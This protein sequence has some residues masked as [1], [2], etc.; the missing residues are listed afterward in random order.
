MNQKTDKR[1]IFYAVLAGLA[2]IATALPWMRIK[3]AFVGGGSL[4]SGLTLPYT[5]KTLINGTSTLAQ[6]LN[7]NL[8][9][10]INALG[11]FNLSVMFAVSLLIYIEPVMYGIACYFLLAKK[12]VDQFTKM[13]LCGL[14]VTAAMSIY[15]LLACIGLN[16]QVQQALGSSLGT[17][18]L[19]GIAQVHFF[20]V[21]SGLILA[22]VISLFGLIY[23]LVIRQ[24]V[25][26]G[27]KVSP[28]SLEISGIQPQFS[29]QP[30]P[31][32]QPRPVQPEAG[33]PHPAAPQSR[34]TIA[35]R[36][37]SGRQNDLMLT[38]FPAV[39]GRDRRQ[40]SA[41]LDDPSVGA[42]H[43]VINVEQGQVVICDLGSVKGTRI[44]GEKIAADT[45][46]A[47]MDGD[48][49]TIGDV[50][51]TVDMDGDSVGEKSGDA[52]A[53]DE[54]GRTTILADAPKAEANSATIPINY[55]GG[56]SPFPVKVMAW[57]DGRD[58]FMI[59]KTPF[60]LG[61]EAEKVDYVIEDRGIS[62]Q[63]LAITR[64]NETFFAEDLNSKNG[65]K[66]N[67]IQKAPGA[68]AKIKNGD[69]LTIGV[70][71]YRFEDE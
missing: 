25:K 56:D 71:R 7:V 28:F 57:L 52:A 64:E 37:E 24:M 45:Y 42:R 6:A 17:V 60:I 16:Q 70:R 49:V 19:S 13:I 12:D 27:Q 67:G 43:C 20:H 51:M 48:S 38:R 40:A 59:T 29:N 26:N 55:N 2:L 18:G 44:E 30:H 68:K 15:A 69:V 36:S 34:R 41:V 62:R 14:I 10:L 35:L 4:G 33:M 32:P 63:H 5:I 58:T 3:V 61:R 8:S 47:I 9:D 54:E 21:G 65:F 50:A 22:L 31:A 39:I 11:P 66:L 23:T 1:V 53:A 46:Y